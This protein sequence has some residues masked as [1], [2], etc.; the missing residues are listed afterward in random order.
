VMVVIKQPGIDIA[1][2]QGRL[3]SFKIHKRFFYLTTFR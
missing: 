2:M 3:N 1:F